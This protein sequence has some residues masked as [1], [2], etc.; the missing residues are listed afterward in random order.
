MTDIKE[1]RKEYLKVPDGVYAPY[2]FRYPGLA[3]DPCAHPAI[4]RANGIYTLFTDSVPSIFK[5][6]LVAGDFHGLYVHEDETVLKYEENYVG[7]IGS[8]NFG[9][10]FD[11]FAPDYRRILKLGLPGLRKK[12]KSSIDKY[13]AD[14]EKTANLKAMYISL[15]GFS[16]L[17]GN[18]IS[19][20]RSKK[21][22]P[23][24]DEEALD[25][26]IRTSEK[27]LAS[28]PESFEEALQL[29]W[30]CHSAFTIEGRY[31]MALGRLDQYLYPFYR[32]D[33][34]SG[35]I[36]ES[37]TERLLESIFVKIGD[38]VVNICVGGSDK[39]GNCEINDLSYR[40]VS[41]VKTCNV[42]GP[43]LSARIT[44]DTPDDFLI[45]CLKSIGTGLGYPAL[46]ND[47]VNIAGL[48]RYGY[49]PEDLH[50]FC[51]VGCIEN[52]IPGK[53][54][55]WSDGRF[56]PPR[57]IDYVLNHGK[58]EFN[59]TVGLDLCDI[60]EIDS[61]EKFMKYY[62]EEIAF[63]VKEYVAYFRAWNGMIDQ[64]Y[65]SEPFLSI[66]CYDCIGRG[67]D[68]NCGGS[69]Y[70]SAHGAAVMGVGTVADSLAA[71]ETVVFRDRKATLAEVRDAIKSN[72]EGYE[73]LRGLL[74]NAPKYGNNDETADKYAVWFLDYISSEFSKYKTRDGGPFYVLMA[75]NTANISAG[76]V[77]PATPDG[78]LQGEPLS[79]AASPTYGR[80]TLGPTVT[81]ASVSKPDYTKSAGGT[82]VNQKYS[83]SAFDD[84]RIKNLAALVR[85]YFKKG[86]QEIQIN[87]TSREVLLD[88]M[89]HPEN[90][91]DLVVRV[92]GFS[93]YYVT[94]GRSVQLDILNR[95]Q[96]K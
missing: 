85:V 20:A 60:S 80:D 44:Q 24:Y 70:P 83:P 73:E 82:V 90:Y 29:V 71:L 61:M 13:A 64:R 74:L 66:F 4:M 53:Q 33:I 26:I 38:D 55:P 28:A 81:L 6:D 62:E 2:H 86:G 23:G 16:N 91:R 37:E 96:H 12:I 72:F 31:A 47:E 92:S 56:D 76:E 50:D 1:L 89:D 67:M 54:P 65:Y 19:S 15:E 52:F 17:I 41:A 84:S 8:R 87:A 21:N 32:K 63:G 95:T 45:E 27:L 30:Y 3:K 94:L 78:R 77:I 7:I 35:K 51:M 22:E 11:H 9:T 88:A 39:D 49:E 75:A 79:D 93:A 18:Y 36:T 57:F 69:K 14:P 25:R 68:I 42:P 59:K 58:C 5:N 46:M 34:D 43:N 48:S 10:N 40:I